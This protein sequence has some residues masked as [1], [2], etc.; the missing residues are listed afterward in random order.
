[1]SGERLVYDIETDG[2]LEDVTVIHHISMRG[3]DTGVES[4]YGPGRIKAALARLSRA[5]ERI[6]HNGVNY[7]EQVIRKLH[8]EVQL[9]PAKLTDTLLLAKLAFPNIADRDFEL[10]RKKKL[11]GNLIGSHSLEAW[12]LRLGF[13]K[14]DYAS[15]MKARG[16][17]PWAQWSPEMGFY[18]DQDVRVTAALLGVIER[19]GVDPRASRMEHE[20]AWVLAEVEQQGWPFD[21]AAAEKLYFEICAERERVRQELT[22]LFPARYV[23]RGRFVPKRPNRN[24]GY[25]K[26]APL[27]K[28]ELLV[29]NPGSRKQVAENLKRKYGW[30]PEEFTDTG[31]PKINDEI[32]EALPYPEAKELARYFMLTKRAGQIGEGDNA[33]LKMAR[34]DAKGQYR[35]HGRIDQLGTVSGRASHSS[36]NVAQVPAV[37]KPYGPEC[38]ALFG[39]GKGRVQLGVDVSG[40]ELRTLGHF[41]FPWDDGKYIFLVTEGDVHTANQEAAGLPTR[42]MAKTFISMG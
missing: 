2:L 32:L 27:H 9:D 22:D 15:V 35:I 28:V 24:V 17:D 12:G 19:K 26:G 29:F 41:L 34:K 40:L 16:L 11:P 36:P 18:C 10:H 42:N 21:Y 39:P 37:D 14:D 7:D 4:S 38:R 3:L 23:D 31:E 13:P 20:L 25:E 8:P 6:A 1:M 30:E 5:R 33:W